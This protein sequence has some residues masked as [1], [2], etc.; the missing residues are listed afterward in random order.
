MFIVRKIHLHVGSGG[1]TVEVRTHEA[2][3][4]CPINKFSTVEKVLQEAYTLPVRYTN[5]M[6]QLFRYRSV[7][8]PDRGNR[9]Q[10]TRIIR[11]TIHLEF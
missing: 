9:K 8:I 4:H 2:P 10:R 3:I 7:Q 5:D 11:D 6:P 1:L